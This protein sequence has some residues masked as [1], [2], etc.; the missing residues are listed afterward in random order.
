MASDPQF[1]VTATKL[2]D[3]ASIAFAITPGTEDLPYRTRY[4]WVGTTGDVVVEMNGAEVVFTNVPDGSL[5]PIRVDKVL[6]ETSGSPTEG[7]TDASDIVGL[8]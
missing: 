5:L 4:L 2:G 3:P 1:S 7:V 6:A 8:Y